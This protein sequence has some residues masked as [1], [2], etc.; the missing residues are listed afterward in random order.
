MAEGMT[1][2]VAGLLCLGLMSCGVESRTI[3][4]SITCYDDAGEITQR[5]PRTTNYVRMENVEGVPA[6]IKCV[7]EPVK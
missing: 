4:I 2:I 1:Y 7:M 5:I 3:P 6:S